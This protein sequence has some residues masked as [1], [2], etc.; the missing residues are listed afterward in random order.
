MCTCDARL[1][2]YQRLNEDY[3]AHISKWKWKYKL[4]TR[5]NAESFVKSKELSIITIEIC[6]IS[7]FFFL[8]RSSETGFS[9]FLS[10]Y[11]PLYFQLSMENIKKAA[12]SLKQLDY[13]IF[14]R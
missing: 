9:D 3:S 12:G 1:G 11:F 4:M 13:R 5:K 10:V 7:Y 2:N 14:I 6:R 8:I